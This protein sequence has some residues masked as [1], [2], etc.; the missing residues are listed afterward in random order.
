MRKLKYLLLGVLALV[1]SSCTYTMQEGGPVPKGCCNHGDQLNVVLNEST[2][3]A[4]AD[5]CND[6]GG[7]ILIYGPYFVCMDVDF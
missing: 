1:L 4:A 7:K 2:L 6:M 5:R 3:I